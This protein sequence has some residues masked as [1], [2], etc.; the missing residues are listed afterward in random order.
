MG[1]ADAHHYLQGLKKAESD[2]KG[3]KPEAWFGRLEE[4][5]GQ[6]QGALQWFLDHEDLQRAMELTA[7]VWR[8]WMNRGHIDE[9]R[10]WLGAVLA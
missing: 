2:L 1:E 4:E 3:P 9:G 6:L 5:H 7:L 10:K 8:F